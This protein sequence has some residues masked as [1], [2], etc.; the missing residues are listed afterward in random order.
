MQQQWSKPKLP[1]KKGAQFFFR[2]P[3]FDQI[4][5]KNTNFAPPPENCAQKISQNPYFYR[6]KKDGQV[7]DPTMAKLLTLKWPKNGQ[8]IDPT[9][10]IYIYA[11]KL[12][13]GPSLGFLN[14][15]IWSKLG[16]LNV[17]IWSKFVF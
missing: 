16:F 13:S 1:K 11:V 5:F 4:F 10:Y 15:I 17:I 9:A 3:F 14:V 6:L 7:I 8:V 12:L 2:K